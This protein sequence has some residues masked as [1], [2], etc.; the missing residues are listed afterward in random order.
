MISNMH[1]LCVRNNMIVHAYN[2]CC[3]GTDDDYA[4]VCC[5]TCVV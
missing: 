2:A 1:M 3:G 4:Y 5:G